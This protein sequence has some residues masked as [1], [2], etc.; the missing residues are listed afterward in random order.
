MMPSLQSCNQTRRTHTPY[1]GS[2][3]ASQCEHKWLPLRVPYKE[4]RR[5]SPE[6]KSVSCSARKKRSG[7]VKWAKGPCVSW[8]FHCATSRIA[9][10]HSRIQSGFSRCGGRLSAVRPHTAQAVCTAAEP[11]VKKNKQH[12]EIGSP[13]LRNWR[14]RTPMALCDL[15]LASSYIWHQP[16]VGSLSVFYKKRAMVV[17]ILLFAKWLKSS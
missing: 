3:I 2:L 15:R 10:H 6:A 12:L 13:A 7:S 16:S 8:S 4:R 17:S 11:N 14:Q 5:R 9:R 1:A